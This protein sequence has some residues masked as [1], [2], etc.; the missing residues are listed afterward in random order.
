MCLALGSAR[1]PDID[2]CL[3]GGPDICRRRPTGGRVV[4]GPS[5]DRDVTSQAA[6]ATKTTSHTA[7]HTRGGIRGARACDSP[8]SSRSG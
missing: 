1:E 4:D 2:V 5:D 7:R 6:T 8:S 3:L